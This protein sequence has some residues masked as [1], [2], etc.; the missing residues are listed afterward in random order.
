MDEALLSSDAE[1]LSGV[2]Q[3]ADLFLPDVLDSVG[4][5]T[6]LVL[7]EEHWD[8]EIDD[9]EIEPESFESLSTVA[10]FVREKLG[11]R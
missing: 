7:I 6:L 1:P 10:D 8:L 4:V 3:D 2:P 5:A 11:E 9:E